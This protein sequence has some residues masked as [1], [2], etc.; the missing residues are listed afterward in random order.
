LGEEIGD[1]STAACGQELLVWVWGAFMDCIVSMAQ[2]VE[3]PFNSKI[4]FEM[5]R[6]QLIKKINHFSGFEKRHFTAFAGRI[7]RQPERCIDSLDSTWAQY[8]TV[9]SKVYPTSLMPP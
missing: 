8:Y 1:I 5:L 3:T 4:I 9:L 7:D 2:N 6:L